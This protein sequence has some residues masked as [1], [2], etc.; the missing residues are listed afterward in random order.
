LRLFYKP[1]SGGSA[2]K[3]PGFGV[4]LGLFFSHKGVIV[5]KAAP[6]FGVSWAYFFLAQGGCEESDLGF[7]VSWAYFLAVGQRFCGKQ[8]HFLA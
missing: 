8:P 6:V 3:R 2:G 1:Q 4:N 7:W 5:R